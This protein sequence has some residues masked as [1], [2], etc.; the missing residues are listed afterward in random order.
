[1][2]EL[3]LHPLA[4]AWLRQLDQAAGVLPVAEREELVADIRAHLGEA[5]PPGAGEAEVRNALDRLGDPA[6]I[7]SEAAGPVPEPP[8]RGRLEWFAIVLVLAGGFLYGIG[9]V[10]GVVLLWSSKAWT[11]RDKLIGTLVPPG[12]L[13]AAAVLLIYSLAADTYTCVSTGP[14]TSEV[15]TGKPSTAH[16]AALIALF[17]ASLVLPMLTAVYLARRADRPRSA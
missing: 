8:R 10:V 5:L 12:G 13:A 11:V 1:M 6:E 15:C 17:T 7:V 2:T 9:W 3:T 4:E 16:Q 14:Q